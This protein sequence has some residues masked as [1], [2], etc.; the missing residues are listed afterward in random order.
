MKMLRF[1]LRETRMDR[2]RN[3]RGTAQVEQLGDKI[4]AQVWFE[5]VRR[6]DSGYIVQ[7]M[8]NMEL[9]RRRK[10]GRFIDV[11]KEDMW[12]G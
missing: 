1:I 9:P 7:R 11:M 10:R 8:L 3:I 5:Q 6:R 12:K 2:I 4:E